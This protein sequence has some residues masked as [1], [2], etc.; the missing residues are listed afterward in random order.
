LKGN[1]RTLRRWLI[2]AV[3]AAVT[4][5]IG[6]TSW[7]DSRPAPERAPERAWSIGTPD[8]GLDNVFV[9][10]DPNM[11]A[12]ITQTHLVTLFAGGP[13]MQ[14]CASAVLTVAPGQ[15]LVVD[16]KLDGELRCANALCIARLAAYWSPSAEVRCQPDKKLRSANGS[17]V[18]DTTCESK[19]ITDSSAWFPFGL[20]AEVKDPQTHFVLKQ[21]WSAAVKCAKSTPKPGCTITIGL[22]AEQ[23]DI[24]AD[25]LTLRL[26]V[27]RS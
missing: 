11:V 25:D 23:G 6:V 14:P 13:N 7:L 8:C 4:V 16:V 2:A 17:A 24:E 26:H 1:R 10:Q 9:P 15:E 3:V 22:Q 27:A 18:T 19:V 5:A 21:Y 20:P 12:V